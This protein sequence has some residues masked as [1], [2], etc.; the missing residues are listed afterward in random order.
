MRSP[1]FHRFL[2]ATISMYKPTG[3]TEIIGLLGADEAWMVTDMLIF[4]R[5]LDRRPEDPSIRLHLEHSRV[6]SHPSR[7]RIS[8]R[9]NPEHAALRTQV[10]RDINHTCARLRDGD[11]LILVICSHASL[12]KGVRIGVTPDEE[13]EEDSNPSFSWITCQDLEDAV[14]KGRAGKVLFIAST[15]YAGQF[16]SDSWKLIAGSTANGLL[17]TV[18]SFAPEQFRGGLLAHA[19][20]EVASISPHVE[21]CD[22]SNVRHE[23]QPQLP[24]GERLTNLK[25]EDVEYPLSYEGRYYSWYPLFYPHALWKYGLGHYPSKT[26]G[27][28]NS[29]ASRSAPTSTQ[30]QSV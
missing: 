15:C 22:P 3:I 12:E 13:G 14:G 24:H 18:T 25:F 7:V 23:R 20:E 5:R 30:A 26:R 17:E 2:P 4:L 27:K 10:L 11:S 19:I 28:L 9:P 16:E 6:P 8:P 1:L 21:I 29:K